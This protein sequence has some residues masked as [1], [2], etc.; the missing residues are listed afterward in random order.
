MQIYTQALKQFLIAD[1]PTHRRTPKIN[2]PKMVFIIPS[3]Q[4]EVE[5]KDEKVAGYLAAPRGSTSAPSWSTSWPRRNQGSQTQTTPATRRDD[6]GTRARQRRDAFRPASRDVFC[7]GAN[8]S[9]PTR[10]NPPEYFL[11]V[12]FIARARFAQ[13][14]PILSGWDTTH[15]LTWRAAKRIGS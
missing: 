10:A 3:A 13:A 6:P 12:P 8:S 2:G 11:S 9:S 5:L 15:S 1:W 7:T 4:R 14:W